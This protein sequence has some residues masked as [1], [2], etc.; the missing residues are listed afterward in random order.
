MFQLSGFYY[1]TQTRNSPTSLPLQ[2]PSGLA[3]EVD[4]GVSDE[5]DWNSNAMCLASYG[6]GLRVDS[7]GYSAAIKGLL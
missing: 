4:A 7:S 2:T 5:D 1:G 3:T 6:L